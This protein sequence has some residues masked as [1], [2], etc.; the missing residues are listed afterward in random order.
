MKLKMI[1]KRDLKKYLVIKVR[2][3]IGINYLSNLIV[4][5]KKVNLEI[6]IIKMIEEDHLLIEN[7]KSY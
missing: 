4:F 5:K 1:L 6:I 3:V 2:I 7:Q